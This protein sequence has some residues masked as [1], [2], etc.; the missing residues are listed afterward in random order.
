MLTTLLSPSL[1]LMQVI[2]G[3]AHRSLWNLFHAPSSGNATVG[4]SS[5]GIFRI[6]LII[7]GMAVNNLE[8]RQREGGNDVRVISVS[9]SAPI[10]ETEREKRGKRK[11][12]GERSK[13]GVKEAVREN[14]LEWREWKE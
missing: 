6:S 10:R 5:S 3:Q 8:G 2:V 9:I 14:K 12:S 1:I 11:R 13:E 4:F 7:R